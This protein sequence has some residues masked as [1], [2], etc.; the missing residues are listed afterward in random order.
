VRPGSQVTVETRNADDTL[1]LKV[2]G[3]RVQ[4]GRSAAQKVWVQAA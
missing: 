4:L 3:Q 2:G 1:T